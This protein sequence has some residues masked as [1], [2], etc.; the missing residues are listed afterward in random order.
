MASESDSPAENAERPTSRGRPFS[1]WSETG[2]FLVLVV[3]TGVLGVLVPVVHVVD[4]VVV[5][6]GLVATVGTVLVIGHGVLGGRLV[7]VVVVLVQSV[8][9]SVVHVVDVVVVL[10]GLVTAVG[11]VR[12]LGDG[13]LCVDF[14]SAHGVPFDD[15]GGD[16]GGP[17]TITRYLSAPHA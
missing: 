5:R 12:V 2:S 8:V 15:L 1:V 17:A 7:L 16:R 9:V 10:D 13:V 11:A 6:D 4:V 14:G 3:V